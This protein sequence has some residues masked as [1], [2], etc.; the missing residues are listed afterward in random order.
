MVRVS[1]GFCG[2]VSVLVLDVDE[3]VWCRRCRRVRRP[4][5]FVWVRKKGCL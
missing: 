1:C 4:R 2:S 3:Y 5:G